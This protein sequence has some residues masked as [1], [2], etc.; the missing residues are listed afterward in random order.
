M[1]FALLVLFS[2]CYVYITVL[3]HILEYNYLPKILKGYCVHYTHKFLV[4][5]RIVFMIFSCSLGSIPILPRACLVPQS[6]QIRVTPSILD[7]AGVPA[8]GLPQMGQICVCRLVLIFTA[9]PPTFVNCF[10]QKAFIKLK[11]SVPFEAC[12]NVP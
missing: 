10:V 7:I 1:A 11:C 2:F 12:L 5:S 9:T 8:K 4:C 3:S 6:G